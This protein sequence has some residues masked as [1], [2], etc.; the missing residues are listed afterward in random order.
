MEEL[1]S[2]HISTELAA[3]RTVKGTKEEMAMKSQL[4]NAKARNEEN[5]KLMMTNLPRAEK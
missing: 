3:G 2:D 4:P 5:M 1:V